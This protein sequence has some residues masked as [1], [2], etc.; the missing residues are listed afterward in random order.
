VALSGYFSQDGRTTITG[1]KTM[2][3]FSIAAACL[4]TLGTF[5]GLPVAAQSVTYSDEHTASCLDAGNTFEEK[6]ACIGVSANACMEDSVGGFSTVGMGA[7]LN[8]ELRWWDARLNASYRAVMADDK[9]TDAQYIADQISAPSLAK[10][11]KA[12]QRAWIPYR[13]N[14]CNYESAQFGGGTGQGPAQLGC[15]LTMTAEQTLFL[16]TGSE[17]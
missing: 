14:R 2:K 17:Q 11:L 10:A 6:K 15:L 5:P 1:K 13:D 16:E 4:V 3:I 9:A 8:R 12:M 7:C